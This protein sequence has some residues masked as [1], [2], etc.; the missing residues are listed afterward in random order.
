MNLCGRRGRA[1]LV[2]GVLLVVGCFNPDQ[3]EEA[4]GESE[5]DS[6]AEDPGTDEGD[7]DDDDDDD[8]TGGDDDDDDDATGSSDGVD[9]EETCAQYCTVMDDHCQDDLRQYPGVAVCESVCGLMN[10]GSEGDALGNSVACR[11]HHAL[12]A[13]EMA[14][15]HCMHAGPSGDTTCGSPCESFCSLALAACSD[16]VRPWADADECIADCEEWNPEPR[17]SAE[18]PDADTYACRLHH[19]TLASL[20]PE[21]HCSHLGPDSPVCRD[22]AE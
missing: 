6:E 21:I 18:A 14:D 22:Q 16:D 1:A 9:A 8:D 12:L 17:Y 11:S 20:Q 13:A 4:I 15:P 7:D 10:P 19:L 3:G 2:V 5:V